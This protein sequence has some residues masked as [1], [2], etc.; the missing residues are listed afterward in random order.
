MLDEMDQVQE[1]NCTTDRLS[2]GIIPGSDV[3]LASRQFQIGNVVCG[4]KEWGCASGEIGAPATAFTRKIKSVSTSMGEY[5]PRIVL[6]TSDCSPFEAFENQDIDIWSE[7]VAQSGSDLRAHK[8]A[9]GLIPE[10][11]SNLSTRLDLIDEDWGWDGSRT[12]SAETFL[13]NTAATR[14]SLMFDLRFQVSFRFKIRA[15]TNWGFPTLFEFESWVDE[16]MTLTSQAKASVNAQYSGTL[17]RVLLSDVIIFAAPT[18]VG[19]VGLEFGLFGDLAMAMQASVDGKFDGE[20]GVTVSRGGK[21]GLRWD[22]SSERMVSINQ[23]SPATKDKTFNWGG[24]VVAKLMPALELKTALRAGLGLW[25]GKLGFELSS[26]LDLGVQGEFQHGL[27]NRILQPVAPSRLGDFVFRANEQH[28]QQTHEAEA[29]VVALLKWKGVQYSLIAFKRWSGNLI[30]PVT[31]F[32]VPLFI[33]C[34]AT[35]GAAGETLDYE[36]IDSSGSSPT[37]E[38]VESFYVAPA[39]PPALA[40]DC[41]PGVDC[42]PQ[43]GTCGQSYTATMIGFPCATGC[44]MGPWYSSGQYAATCK[45]ETCCEARFKSPPSNGQHKLVG[46]GD[47]TSSSL[48]VPGGMFT[49]VRCNVGYTLSGRNLGFQGLGSNANEYGFLLS[50]NSNSA[51]RE[52]NWP[53]ASDYT[54]CTNSGGNRRKMKVASQISGGANEGVSLRDNSCRY[55]YDGECDEPTYC[56]W[57]T[58]SSDCGGSSP[59]PPP[60]ASSPSNTVT[61]CRFARAIPGDGSWHLEERT[62]TPISC[63]S[64]SPMPTNGAV[65]PTGARTYGQ[66][67][68]ITCNTGFE[69]TGDA[70]FSATPS[71]QANGEFTA[72]KM[73]ARKACGPFSAIPNGAAFPASGVLSGQ[74]AVVS[75]DDGYEVLGDASLLCDRGE[76]QFTTSPSC[77]RISCGLLSV[78]NGMSQRQT[79]LLFGDTEEI[80]CNAGFDF[81]A[82]EMHATCTAFGSSV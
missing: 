41:I 25:I 77:V 18:S 32:E 4:G 47:W 44:A 12:F 57:G 55:A 75:C 36:R 40:D 50:E 6:S 46:S 29:Q 17:R 52:W 5:L 20:L 35:G 78:E 74:R 67:V 61:D 28:C 31:L 43:P 49:E 33:A 66:T 62:C 48:T 22:A 16:S 81:S 14:V 38:E 80:Q 54:P 42:P 70:R 30:D 37:F 82:S 34:Y 53:Q 68:T 26:G 71:C 73:C 8:P 58:D 51:Y 63:G 64:Y 27:G 11:H 56:A 23:F 65:T 24:K 60:T 59:P 69:L 45:Q 72:G 2:I 13:I 76:Y 9:P 7:E 19:G 21:Y 3:D 79:P 10:S 1:V 39:P 15:G